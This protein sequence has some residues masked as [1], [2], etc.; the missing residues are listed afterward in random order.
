MFEPLSKLKNA[1][2]EMT[3]FGQLGEFLDNFQANANIGTAANV[4]TDMAQLDV[5]PEQRGTFTFNFENG[6]IVRAYFISY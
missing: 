2:T 1:T 6:Q 4:R 5:K 3:T